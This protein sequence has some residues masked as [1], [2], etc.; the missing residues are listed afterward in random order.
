VL[1]VLCLDQ[2]GFPLCRVVCL[3]SVPWVLV[4]IM[5]INDETCFIFMYISGCLIQ[6]YMLKRNMENHLR[7]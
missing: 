4:V 1:F 3:V 7:K 5:N 6:D 2:P